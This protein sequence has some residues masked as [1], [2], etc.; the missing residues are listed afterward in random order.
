MY[1]VD[2]ILFV[3]GSQFSL[4]PQIV[5]FTPNNNPES[6]VWPSFV[7]KRRRVLSHHPQCLR[8]TKAQG[9]VLMNSCMGQDMSSI[10]GTL[11]RR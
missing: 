6:E 3:R 10:I 2:R 5:L 11:E 4:P 1:H 8:G 9:I 7:V